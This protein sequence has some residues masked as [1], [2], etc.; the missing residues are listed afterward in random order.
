MGIVQKQ[1]GR[2]IEVAARESSTV[3]VRIA[4]FAKYEFI[5]SAEKILF[6]SLVK[7]LQGNE[8][9]LSRS[10]IWKFDSMT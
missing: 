8:L 4:S 6:F 3:L 10:I 7:L 1:F 9:Y 5:I 2:L